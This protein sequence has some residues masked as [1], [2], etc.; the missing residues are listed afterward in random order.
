VEGGHARYL[1]DLRYLH[2]RIVHT[3][4]D[5]QMDGWR[6]RWAVINRKCFT[7]KYEE[8]NIT[9]RRETCKKEKD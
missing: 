9:C 4:D 1:T 6:E 7:K 3:E 8:R 2:A 5:I